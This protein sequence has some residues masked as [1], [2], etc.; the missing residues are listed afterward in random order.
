MEIEIVKYLGVKLVINY[1]VIGKYY[2][3]TREEPE[4]FPDYEICKVFVEDTDITPMLLD[5][6]MDDIYELLMVR[7]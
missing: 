3:A 5:V 4:E 1:K 7:I 6:Q 2:P